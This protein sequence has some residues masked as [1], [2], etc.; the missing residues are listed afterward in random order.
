ME[1]KKLTAYQ[2]YKKS[3]DENLSKDEYRQLLK[4]NYV[5]KNKYE[6]THIVDKMTVDEF[7]MKRGFSSS[8]SSDPQERGASKTYH[9]DDLE[10]H[11]HN[12][13]DAEEGCSFYF[14][15]PSELL[16]FIETLKK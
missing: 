2:C 4:D 16:K 12:E 9:K 11:M 6:E 3:L 10:V 13:D 8:F 1:N 7:L 5:I 14:K 15:K